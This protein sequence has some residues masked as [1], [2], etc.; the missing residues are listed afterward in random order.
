MKFQILTL[1]PDM[2]MQG[3]NTSIIGRAVENKLIE[4]DAVNI[5][6]YTLDKHGKVDDYPYGGGAGML[7]QAQPVFDAYQ[8]VT[9]DREKKPRTIYVTPQGA[10]FNQAM[11][12][13]FAGEEELV[14]LCG[15]YEGIDQRVLDEIVTDYVSIGDYVLTGGELPAMVMIDAISRL[16]P[17]VLNNDVSAETES[18]YNDLL[19]YPQYSRPEIWHDKKVPEVLL[20]GNHKKISEWR[21]EQSVALTKVRRPDLYKKYEKSMQ[22]YKRL[23]KQKRKYIHMM[24]Q[25]AQGRAIMLYNKGMD[26]LLMDKFSGIYMM[27][28]ESVESAKVMLHESGMVEKIKDGVLM[29]VCDPELK[30]LLIMEYG[31]ETETPCYQACYTSR[32]TLPVM[33]KDIRPLTLEHKEYVK[34]HYHSDM[35]YIEARI[36]AGVMYG[37]FVEDKLIG[38]IGGHRE[39]SMGMLFVEETYRRSGIAG[40]LEAFVINRLL[41]QG[42]TPYCH[43]YEGNVASFKLQEKKGLYLCEEPLWWIWSK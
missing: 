36:N 5:R 38:F 27:S 23:K 41:E 10:T 1:F 43:I 24:E 20:S 7:M 15:H 16:V 4:I 17:G 40:S 34:E 14:F 37:A 12:E 42:K 11:A 32:E 25:I 18:F 3:L 29:I 6:D 2:V 21:L 9:K 30:D 26:I 33:H 19:E 31:M 35:K 28:A 22:A 8:A 13:E 39:G